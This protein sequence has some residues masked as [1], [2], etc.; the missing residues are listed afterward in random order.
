MR[1]AYVDKRD[2]TW[3]RD[4]PRFRIF[5]FKGA[6]DEV[7][8]VD[9][10]DATL[11]EA[12]D[13]ARAF[14]NGD[15]DLWSMAIVDDD[16][17]GARGL[18]WLSGMNYNDTPVTARQW[19]LRRQMQSRYLSA[20]TRRGLQPLLPNGLRLLRVFPEWASG[21]PLW[22]D[23]TDGYRFDVGS[24]DISPEL[25]SALFDWN[26]EWLTRQEDEPLADAEGWRERGVLLVEQLQR[27]L[28]GVAEVRPEFSEEQHP[29]V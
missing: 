11:D 20:R 4:D 7:T 9:L 13:G 1:G 8:A 19:Q 26:E 28:N 27:E 14:S 16:S 23:F 22:E 5:V 12:M 18:I 6:V 2:S 25:S 21:W 3:E 17:R 24:L 10:V 29:F 15:R